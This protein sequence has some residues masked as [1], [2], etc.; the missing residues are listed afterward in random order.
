MTIPATVTF[1]P[2]A[3]VSGQVTVTKPV[4]T[5][6]VNKRI[7]AAPL[8][9]LVWQ[10]SDLPTEPGGFSSLPHGAVAGI[11]SAV[12][13]TGLALLLILIWW[14][15][16]KKR[17]E[18]DDHSRTVEEPKFELDAT[19]AR[20]EADHTHTRAEME[21]T[22]RPAE[23]HVPDYIHEA[24]S[25]PPPFMLSRYLTDLEDSNMQVK[26]GDIVY[27]DNEKKIPLY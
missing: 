18:R 10:A 19:N 11:A 5:E 14:I 26:S 2:R 23:L 8:V 16:R 9:Q 7:V 13:I 21:A 3:T 25:E 20:V 17:R 22:D 27:P 1:T 12:S 4:T 6:V 24:P 15:M